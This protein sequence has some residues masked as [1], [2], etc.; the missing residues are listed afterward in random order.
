MPA[1]A[2]LYDALLDRWNQ[3]DPAGYAALFLERSH[4][5][6]FDG[7]QMSG[8]GEIEATLGAIFADHA[9]GAYVG[10][11]QE[12]VSLAE[13]IALIRAVCGIV[14]AGAS[15]LNPALNAIQT[16][17]AKRE[18]GEWKIALFQN[19]PAQFHG[20]P[21]LSEKLTDALRQLLPR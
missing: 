3:R 7:S 8:R 4:V 10:F 2:A 20:R 5:V 9:T 16:L 13:D 17:L 1:P 18:A 12:E 21:E 11:V 19:T 15:D 14:P 6:G